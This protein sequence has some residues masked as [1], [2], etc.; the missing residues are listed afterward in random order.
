MRRVAIGLTGLLL[1]LTAF[2]RANAHATRI[3]SVSAAS[4]PCPDKV[5][6]PNVVARIEVG[7]DPWSVVPADGS[8]WVGSDLGVARIDPMTNEVEATVPIGAIGDVAVADGRVWVSSFTANEVG[9]VDVVTNTVPHPVHVDGPSRIVVGEDAVWAVSPV[10]GTV[11]RIDPA[12]NT[13]VATI[14]VAEPAPGLNGLIVPGAGSLAVGDGAV[15]A[16]MG[17]YGR[18]ARIDPST[19]RVVA[20]I[21]VGSFLPIVAFVDD[22]LWVMSEDDQ[23]LRRIDPVTGRVVATIP[24]HATPFLLSVTEGTLWVSGD[25]LVAEVDTS[26]N[27]ISRRVLAMEGFYGGL[28]SDGGDLWVARLGWTS[29]IGAYEPDSRVL[30]MDMGSASSLP[31]Q[32]T[33]GVPYTQGVPCGRRYV[34]PFGACTFRTDVYSTAGA[35]SEPIIILAHGGPCVPGCPEYLAQQASALSLE[36]TV[37]FNVDYRQE[38]LRGKIVTNNASYHDL[39]CAIRFARANATQY[40]GDPERVTLVGQ[41]FGS[42]IGPTVAL[43]GND[44]KGGCLAKGRGAPDAFVGLSGAPA[45]GTSSYIGRNPYLAFRYI[46]GSADS[47]DFD[48]MRAFVRDLRK[49]GYDATYTLVEGA[50]HN[51]LFTPGSASPAFRIILDVARRSSSADPGSL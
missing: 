51:D 9:E 21:R 12:T 26:T 19:N 49:A 38:K 41:S 45:P 37:V 1:L 34:S 42:I 36:G 23:S 43:G 3:H 50:G 31:V 10:Q 24:L 40:G 14:V 25:R 46:A 4:S 44:F 35:D 29:T 28:A 5:C 13:I 18:I 30:R 20:R 16:A 27:S 15:W 33:Q 7:A 39:A 48:K 2:V 8:I 11:T 22:A 47:L 6:L 32:V 17:N